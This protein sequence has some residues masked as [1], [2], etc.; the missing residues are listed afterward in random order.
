MPT[1]IFTILLYLIILINQN[2]FAEKEK[3]KNHFEISLHAST[4]SLNFLKSQIENRISTEMNDLFENEFMESINDDYPDLYPT[5]IT[6]SVEFHSGGNHFG[7][8]IR[9][10]PGGKNGSFSLGFTVDKTNMKISL[11]LVKVDMTLKSSISDREGYFRGE[12]THA[13]FVTDPLVFGINLR[14]DIIPTKKFH[15]YITFGLGIFPVN[16]VRNAIVDLSYNGTL[17]VDGEP[18][19][20]IAESHFKTVEDIL[21]E[22]NSDDPFE[23]IPFIPVLQ[24]NIGIKGEIAEN[25]YLFLDFGIWNGLSLSGGVATRF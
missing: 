23:N 8:E 16:A 7:I 2:V 17:Q 1:R 11:P 24:F 4:W 5:E 20:S 19:D 9:W 12:V 21:E 18:D 25:L 13:S 3:D 22:E 10:Y 6:Q 15:P 14:W